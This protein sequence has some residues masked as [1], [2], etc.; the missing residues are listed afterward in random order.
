MLPVKGLDTKKLK[1]FNSI[2]EIKKKYNDV[3]KSGRCLFIEDPFQTSP[4]VF[5]KKTNL[6]ENKILNNIVV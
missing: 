4:Y 5:A 2:D 1:V 6:T 3:K